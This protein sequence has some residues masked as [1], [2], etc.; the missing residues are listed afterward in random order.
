MITPNSKHCPLCDSAMVMGLWQC[1]TTPCL[2]EHFQ[3]M[4][5][6]DDEKAPRTDGKMFNFPSNDSPGWLETPGQWEA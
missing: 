3:I 4:A 5:D 6:N 1:Q 2:K